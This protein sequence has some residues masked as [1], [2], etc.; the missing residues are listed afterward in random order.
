M[1]RYKTI[2]SV[3]I[4]TLMAIQLYAGGSGT[5]KGK[6]VDS[7]T[8]EPIPFANVILKIKDVMKGGASTD[9]DGNYTIKPITPGTYTVNVTYVG[10]NTKEVEN[11][12]IEEN[13]ITF[14]DIE[15]NASL[16][17]LNVVE[18]TDYCVP[19]INKDNTTS[20]GTWTANSHRNE[21]NTKY[22]RSS[23]NRKKARKPVP[24]K[25]KTMYKKSYTKSGGTATAEEIR[26]MPNKTAGSLATT[27]SGVSASYGANPN[28]RGHNEGTVLY[29]DGMRVTRSTCIP[30]DRFQSVT[31]ILGGI[32]AEYENDMVMMNEYADFKTSYKQYTDESDYITT[33]EVFVL[34]PSTPLDEYSQIPIPAPAPDP[35]EYE[36]ESYD[37]II[38]NEFVSP[39]DEPLST[40]SIDVDRASY[41]NIRR[42]LNSGNMPPNDAIRLEEMI[43]YFNYSYE[44]PTDQPFSV[45]NELGECPWNEESKLLHIGIQGEHIEKDDRKPNNLVFLL[46]VSGSMCSPNKL[47]LLKKSFKLLLGQLDERDRVAIVVYAG[48]SGLA[49]PSTS[50]DKKKVIIDRLD[51]LNAGG[52]TA[53]GAGIELAYKV[54][55]ENFIEDGNNRVILATDGD[56]NVGIYDNNALL[57]L[58]DKKKES[59]VYLSVL[60]FGMGNYKDDKMEI[61]AD[62]GN[63]NY[64]YID[65]LK[66]A[67]KVLVTEMQGTLYTIAKD[68]KLQLEF[69]PAIV[70]SYRLVG[71]EN[72]L[73]EAE[74]FDDDKKDAG[75][76]GAGHTVTA[77]YEVLFVD[78]ESG[79]KRD[80]RYQKRG[81]SELKDSEELAFMKIRYKEPKESKSQLLTFP[82]ENKVIKDSGN[83]FG[84]SACVA[85]FGLLLRDSEFIDDA[86]DYE[87][88]LE[89]AKKYKGDDE[90]GYRGE[91]I[92]LVK[93]A[94][95]MARNR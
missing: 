78:G 74:D 84:F 51:E 12:V 58:I 6:V 28:L 19:L 66:E 53:G 7:E 46:D 20:G 75:E 37:E 63:G 77:I 42:M 71:Y 76:I 72:R 89:M 18:I 55:V 95:A 13:M 47:P 15:V 65:N 90:E 82:V 17:Q 48:S 16:T 30:S 80:L 33:P 35:Y 41:S 54:A 14:L 32:P 68:V 36:E 73:L 29:I 25:Q 26:K 10:Y 83:N 27:V 43:N 69:N 31:V 21:R 9:F 44:K 70:K 92:Q 67:N 91:F 49:L 79:M 34:M 57:K 23:K 4:C 24:P 61:L 1:K 85:G 5:L 56:F 40:F 11:V 59:G 87:Q 88:V 60:G 62:H 22:Y 45:Y 38:E 39:Y 81:E 86:F 8:K 52:S 64:A 94:K 93:L 50:C 3:V 2:V